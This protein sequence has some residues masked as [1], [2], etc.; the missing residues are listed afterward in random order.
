MTDLTKLANEI[1]EAIE[2]SE[3]F[4]KFYELQAKQE[5]DSELQMHVG[6]YNLKRMA[7]MN[8]MQ[9]EPDAQDE[10]TVRRLRDEMNAAYT[11]VM[12]NDLMKEYAAASEELQALVNSVYQIINF[13][14]TGEEPHSCDGGCDGCHGCH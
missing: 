6:E 2:T 9:K 7:L 1:G 5:T 3:E 12:C 8:E 10:E 13:H 14:V 11:V 4:K